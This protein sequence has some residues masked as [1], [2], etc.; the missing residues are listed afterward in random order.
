MS[1]NLLTTLSS[2]YDSIA[3]ENEKLKS[4]GLDLLYM[5]DRWWALIALCKECLATTTEHDST[6]GN[7]GNNKG[8]WEGG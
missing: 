1:S 3:K 6:S 4:E 7:G 2:E 5:S 8:P